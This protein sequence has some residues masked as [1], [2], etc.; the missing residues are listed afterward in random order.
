MFP[1]LK[2]TAAGKLGGKPGKTNQQSSRPED[3]AH[4]LEHGPPPEISEPS[5]Y[6]NQSALQNPQFNQGQGQ[7]QGQGQGQGQATQ[8][9]VG[10]LDNSYEATGGESQAH[11]NS[12]PF[13]DA[14][15]AYQDYQ[16]H[17]LH[18][19]PGRLEQRLAEQF[20]EHLNMSQLPGAS[21][22][23]GGLPAGAGATAAALTAMAGYQQGYA[24]SPSS[25]PSPPPPPGAFLPT[26]GSQPSFG[27][28]TASF[29]QPQTQ[30]WQ[31]PSPPHPAGQY[32]VAVPSQVSFPGQ[33]A[34]GQVTY[35]PHLA[36]QYKGYAE[37]SR[38]LD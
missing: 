31:P 33:Q 30:G 9:D 20:D 4:H 24:P 14:Q 16:D 34:P 7:S 22:F 23:A 11:Q 21:P 32:N 17:K 10:Q 18:R 12:N 37:P 19:L 3:V 2:P 15:N 29:G 5:Q 13:Q 6:V 28:S 36:S 38:G 1:S 26:H 25:S 8:N 27:D 35:A